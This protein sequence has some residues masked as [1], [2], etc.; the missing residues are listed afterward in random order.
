[1]ITDTDILSGIHEA[2]RG[3]PGWARA[4]L[5]D[6]CPSLADVSAGLEAHFGV[7]FVGDE[8]ERVTSVR[9]LVELLRRKFDEA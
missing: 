7:A 9:S 8:L 4:E 1:M 5:D 6:P 3:S 2:G